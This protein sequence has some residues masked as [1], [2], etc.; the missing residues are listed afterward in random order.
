ME[1]KV[2]DRLGSGVTFM[3]KAEKDLKVI[4]V[5]FM[6]IFVCQI[7][8]SHSDWGK[9]SCYESYYPRSLGVHTQTPALLGGRVGPKSCRSQ[10][11]SRVIHSENRDHGNKWACVSVALSFW[12]WCLAFLGCRSRSDSSLGRFNSWC[13]RGFGAGGRALRW[14][15]S[16]DFAFESLGFLMLVLGVAIGRLNCFS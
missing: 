12:H 13:V 4:S 5:E 10:A 15:L 14:G 8:C 6:E 9:C 3:Y 1:K 7:L 16:G 11:P 2:E